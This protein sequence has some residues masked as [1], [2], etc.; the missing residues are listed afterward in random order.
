MGP[1]SVCQK[2]VFEKRPIKVGIH[3]SV[4]SDNVLA[5]CARRCGTKGFQV[6]GR[7]GVGH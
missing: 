6:D 3:L 5:C 4:A 1:P 2:V 7:G